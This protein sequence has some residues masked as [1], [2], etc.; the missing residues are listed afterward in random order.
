M[1]ILKPKHQY[2]IVEPLHYTGSFA[3]TLVKGKEKVVLVFSNLF[4]FSNQV[5]PI[6]SRL[7]IVLFLVNIKKTHQIGRVSFLYER[8]IIFSQ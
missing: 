3:Q 8:R 1:I 4:F 2:L 7:I 6:E 5:K